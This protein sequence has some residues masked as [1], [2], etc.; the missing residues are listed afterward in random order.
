MFDVWYG[1]I[2]LTALTCV[3]SVVVLLPIQ[4]L[5]CLKVKRLMI[6]LLPLVIL[7]ILVIIWIVMS[8]A[9]PG[10]DGL[11]FVFLAIF[12]GIM[13]LMCGIGWGIWALVNQAK[14]KQK[15]I[16]KRQA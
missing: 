7:S 11:G 14:K 3:F 10:W 12:I 1:E 9:I 4:L 13:I 16:T 8:L 6:R 5:L 15:R 2:E